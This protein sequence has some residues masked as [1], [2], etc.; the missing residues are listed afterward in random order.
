MLKTQNHTD[1][2]VVP[3]WGNCWLPWFYYSGWVQLTAEF[4]RRGTMTFLFFVQRGSNISIEGGRGSRIWLRGSFVV[5]V[6]QV[7]GS[8]CHRMLVL[9]FQEKN[10][11]KRAI[12]RWRDPCFLFY[13]S[14]VF[15]GLGSKSQSRGS[16]KICM[17]ILDVMCHVVPNKGLMASKWEEGEKILIMD[18]YVGLG[19]LFCKHF[20]AQKNHHCQEQW[21]ACTKCDQDHW[22][23]NS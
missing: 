20:R 17:G 22:C 8:S 19:R 4:K 11:S 6:Y 12:E 5:K 9:G 18:T 7:Q 21:A 1:W 3:C 16:R 14:S 10:L 15:W 2:L 13:W 23:E